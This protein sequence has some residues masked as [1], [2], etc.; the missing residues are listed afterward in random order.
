MKTINTLED[1][2]RTVNDISL[3]I[4]GIEIMIINKKYEIK[5]SSDP[6]TADSKKTEIKE[7]KKEIKKLEKEI[8]EHKAAFASR[9]TDFRPNQVLHVKDVRKENTERGLNWDMEFDIMVE[10][11][12]VY[13]RLSGDMG[14]CVAG[15]KLDGRG[16]KTRSY[17]V[18]AGMPDGTLKENITI[19]PARTEVDIKMTVKDMS[20]TANNE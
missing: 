19:G 13:K 2:E 5:K 9:F 15:H 7:M 20:A 8:E 18:F 10:K 17:Y 11:M 1:L 6:E 12:E 16:R 4:S 14:L 3:K